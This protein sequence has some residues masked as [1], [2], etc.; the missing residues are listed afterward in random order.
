M[1][2]P[3]I[4]ETAALIPGRVVIG[5][6]EASAGSLFAGRPGIRTGGHQFAG[7]ALAA[8]ARSVLAIR[9]AGDE[10]ARR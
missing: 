2:L 10:G 8:G 4:A 9:P 5:S 7:A 3:H 1:H 6:R